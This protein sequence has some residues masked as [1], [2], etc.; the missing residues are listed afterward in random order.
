MLVL[1]AFAPSGL[2]RYESVEPHM[3]TL[4]RITIYA[5]SKRAAVDAFRAA[6]DRIRDLDR[7]LSDYKPDS[8]L[9]A[10]VASAVDRDVPVSDDL[11]AVLQASQSLAEATG[12]AFDITQGPVIRLWR[13]ARKTGRVP[14]AEALRLAAE[15]TGYRHVHLDEHR[16]TVRVDMRGMALDLGAIGKGYAASEA[17][18]TLAARGLSRALVAVSGDLALGDPPPGMN[19]WRVAVP[20]S[21][22]SDVT[23]PGVLELANVAISTSGSSEQ[24]LDAGGR[25]YSHII[26]P[27]SKM[28]LV[29][30][31]TVTVLAPHGLEADGLDT[32]VSVLGVDKGLALIDS[33]P[34][35]AALIVTGE[36]AVASARFTSLI[37]KK[38]DA[39]SED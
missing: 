25:H 9:N 18:G 22:P 20:G 4:V 30:D 12:G 5:P 2:Q 26:D 29:D 37:D 17:L 21:D 16:R 24:H 6:F 27:A 3:G 28:G 8:E 19:G 34:D 39:P 33:R 36:S 23:R 14:D 32:A 38:R 1:T 13:E 7:I 11:F 31:L 35:A 10:M 15:R